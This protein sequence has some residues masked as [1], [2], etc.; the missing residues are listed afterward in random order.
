MIHHQHHHVHRAMVRQMS[1]TAEEP[2][3]APE[4]PMFLHPNTDA[5]VP[6]CRVEPPQIIPMT[7]DLGWVVYWVIQS[8]SWLLNVKRFN[9]GKVN[10]D[11]VDNRLLTGG[12][13]AVK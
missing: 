9:N 4:Y 6:R 12:C 13:E 2:V 3:A 10:K 7:F 8:C 5:Q 11:E 1:C